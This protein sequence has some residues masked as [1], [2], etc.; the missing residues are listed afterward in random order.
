MEVEIDRMVEE[1]S[2]IKA[3][4]ALYLRMQ[5]LFNQI[6]LQWLFLM[7]FQNFRMYINLI[8]NAYTS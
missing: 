5:Y 4:K 8:Y 7:Q 2:S 3:E 1:E 6:I